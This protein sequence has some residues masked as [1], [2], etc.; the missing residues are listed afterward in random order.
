MELT[1]SVL[2][3][4]RRSVRNTTDVQ[5]IL[6]GLRRLTGD[7]EAPDRQ[8]TLGDGVRLTVET[9]DRRRQQHPPSRLWASSDETVTSI[10]LPRRANGGSSAVTMTIATLVDLK[11]WIGLE[12][13]TIWTSR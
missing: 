7:P 6:L 8:R 9:V 11:T 5:L 13:V 12:S 2:A 3:L 10:E 1:Q 4:D